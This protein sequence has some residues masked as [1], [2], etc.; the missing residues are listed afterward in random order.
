MHL[1]VRV[2]RY[3]LRIVWTSST[4]LQ[5]NVIINT[6]I[7]CTKFNVCNNPSMTQGSGR[8][9]GGKETIGESQT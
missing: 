3:N 6:D 7:L 9:T 8:E 2:P 4:Q 1:F 5:T